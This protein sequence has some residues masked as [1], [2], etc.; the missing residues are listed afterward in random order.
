MLSQMCSVQCGQRGV[1]ASGHR[2]RPLDA[3]QLGSALGHLD[4]QAADAPLALGRGRPCV[5]GPQHESVASS[6]SCCAVRTSN[7]R[8]SHSWCIGERTGLG[9]GSGGRCGGRH[10]HGTRGGG[11]GEADLQ[12]PGRSRRRHAPGL[13]ACVQRRAHPQVHDAP[14]VHGWDHVPARVSICCGQGGRLVRRHVLV[15]A[16]GQEVEGGVLAHPA[17]RPCQVP[18]VWRPCAGGH[19]PPGHSAG[20]HQLISS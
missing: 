4:Q 14:G 1:A 12:P 15:I 10:C 19:A 3:A 16:C 17:S 13:R 18:V 11:A 6:S 7:G 5:V 9:G 2:P 8:G 20:P